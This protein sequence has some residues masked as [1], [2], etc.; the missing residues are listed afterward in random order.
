[1]S[2][3]NEIPGAKWRVW[4]IPQVPMKQFNFEV[5]TLGEGRR[6]CDCLAEYDKFQFENRIKPDYCNTGGVQVSHQ[7]FCDGDWE[8]VPDDD[9]EAQFLLEEIRTEINLTSTPQPKE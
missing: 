9:E 3:S 2:E 6:M 7:D 5:P 8:D 1:M 4:W